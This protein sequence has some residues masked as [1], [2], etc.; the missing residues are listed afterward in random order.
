MKKEETL[1]KEQKAE[2]KTKKVL[3]QRKKKVKKIY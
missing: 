2:T 3:I 1:N